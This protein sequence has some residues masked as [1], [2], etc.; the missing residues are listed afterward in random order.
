TSREGASVGESAGRA[1]GRMAGPRGG[2]RPREGGDAG[3]SSPGRVVQ[4]STTER[5]SPRPESSEAASLP[6]RHPGA[7]RP[8]LT[9]T[10]AHHTMQPVDAPWLENSHEI[11]SGLPAGRFSP[12]GAF[13]AHIFWARRPK[14]RALS[15]W[16][17]ADPATEGA[18]RPV[19][20]RDVAAGRRQAE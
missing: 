16:A 2:R 3:P 4:R 15:G 6:N 7:S 19:R 9:G 20:V 1:R 13:R 5:G 14:D 11:L 8:S 18:G 12:S 10:W 17:A